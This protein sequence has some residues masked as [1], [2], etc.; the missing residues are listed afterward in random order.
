MKRKKGFAEL[1]ALFLAVSLMLSLNAFAV[2]AG[3][4]EN[5]GTSAP[6]DN[7]AGLFLYLS[8][9]TTESLSFPLTEAQTA[10]VEK[11]DTVELYTELSW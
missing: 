6:A 3:T 4:E 5:R 1:L 7:S 8:E 11:A 2:Q 10:L 9:G